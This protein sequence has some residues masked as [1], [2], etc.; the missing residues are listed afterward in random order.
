MNLIAQ[1]VRFLYEIVLLPF[2][3]ACKEFEVPKMYTIKL[4][5]LQGGSYCPTLNDRTPMEK[6]RYSKK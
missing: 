5:V 6:Q 3:R 2:A 4:G 1:M